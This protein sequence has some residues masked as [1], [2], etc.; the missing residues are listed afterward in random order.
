MST[1]IRGNF[2]HNL[3]LSKQGFK[4]DESIGDVVR[5]AMYRRSFP[6]VKPPEQMSFEVKV[7]SIVQNDEIDLDELSPVEFLTSDE[8]SVDNDNLIEILYEMDFLGDTENETKHTKRESDGGPN[9][10]PKRR[11]RESSKFET[12][13][14]RN[15]E[16]KEEINSMNEA[17][18]KGI[19]ALFTSIK[20]IRRAAES[21]K[22]ET[23]ENRNAELKEEINS[24]NE[25]ERKGIA[26]LFR[27]IK[28]MRRAAKLNL[29]ALT[30]LKELITKYPS[31]EFLYKILKPVSE[32]MPDTPINT[33]TPILEVAGLDITS[34]GNKYKTESVVKIVP[35]RFLKGGKIY[36]R[37]SLEGCTFER[38]SWGAV[39]THIVKDHIHKSYVC[40][41]CEKVLSSMDGLRRHIKAQHKSDK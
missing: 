20:E 36:H 16:L 21:S 1:V 6:D 29:A 7:Q 4:G 24:M 25:V 41:F 28:E 8:E 39:N 30:R 23:E 40:E 35:K 34:G 11:K 22:V 17:E 5:A 2:V 37:C 10:N 3:F 13:E 26:A 18:R 27:S 14:N 31:L 15:A 12:E 9:E 33:I 19:A 32:I 38:V